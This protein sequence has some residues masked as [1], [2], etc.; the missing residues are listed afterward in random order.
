[1][2][3]Y[4]FL[5]ILL[6]W[7]RESQCVDD[8]KL[9]IS[10]WILVCSFSITISTGIFDCVKKHCVNWTSIRVVEGHFLKLVLREVYDDRM[11]ASNIIQLWKE[12][13][14]WPILLRISHLV[15]GYNIRQKL[16]QMSVFE[17][18]VSFT[19][20]AVCYLN[21][22]NLSSIRGCRYCHVKFFLLK[23]NDYECGNSRL[24]EFNRTKT[25]SSIYYG[26][27]RC[28][29]LQEF[30]WYTLVNRFYSSIML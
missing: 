10:R 30:S 4:I 9:Y 12:L 3:K 15:I 27:C 21:E 29:V 5:V 25:C 17:N 14:T 20:T 18:L 28:G 8:G 23:N 26:A 16:I 22:C 2:V 1:M 24:M 13:R 11:H 6:L 7:L 19:F